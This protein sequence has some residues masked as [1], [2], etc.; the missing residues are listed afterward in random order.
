MYLS[1]SLSL[2]LYIYIYI[3]EYINIYIYVYIYI[4][5]YIYVCIYIYTYLHTYSYIHTHTPAPPAP[6]ALLPARP[7]THHL[8]AGIHVALVLQEERA[9][10]AVAPVGGLVQGRALVLHTG[11]EAAVR[12]RA[13]RGHARALLRAP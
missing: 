8:V 1:L 2:S 4:Y 5:I 7:H 3:C 12:V 11:G 9:G 13:T 10:A 6:L